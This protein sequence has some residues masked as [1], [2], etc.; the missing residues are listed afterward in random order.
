ME[1]I[2]L[3]TM[4]DLPGMSSVKEVV[5]NEEAVGAEATPLMIHAD[6]K[7]STATAG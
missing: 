5:V 6:S 1:E 3:D 4:F 2:L 7:E